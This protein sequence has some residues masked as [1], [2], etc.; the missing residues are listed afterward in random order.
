ME[1][2]LLLGLGLALIA[3]SVPGAIGWANEWVDCAP[4]YNDVRDRLLAGI[5]ITDTLENANECAKRLRYSTKI[6]T[7]DGEIVHSGG[8][9]TGGRNKSQSTPVTLGQERDELAR[10]I[11]RQTQAIEQQN[12]KIRQTER[13]NEDEQE[14]L[15]ALQ[16]ESPSWKTSF[17]SKNKNSTPCKT[18]TIK[19]PSRPAR[20]TKRK[21]TT[22]SW[23]PSPTSTAGSTRWRRK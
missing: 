23:Q 13:R 8:A 5:F 20:R 17:L 18:N 6:V 12:A 14:Q 9:M 15:I 21:W 4:K 22:R 11:E 16:I 2:I 19:S 10:K 3:A 1:Y 7:L